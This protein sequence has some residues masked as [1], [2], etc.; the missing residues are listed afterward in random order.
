MDLDSN[1]PEARFVYAIQ[2]F[3]LWKIKLIGR[4][5]VLSGHAGYI[6][7]YEE[8]RD[9]MRPTQLALKC[10]ATRLQRLLFHNTLEYLGTVHRYKVSLG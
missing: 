8:M 2:V 6:V 3:L 9:D 1:K 4:I 10:R 7:W 5:V